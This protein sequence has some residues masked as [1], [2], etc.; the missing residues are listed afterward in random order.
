MI[1]I[2][3]TNS[4]NKDFVDL[5]KLLDADLKKRDGDEH[6]FYAQFNKIDG[7]KNAVV[8]YFD[9]LPVGCGSIKEYTPNIA[10]IKRMYVLPKN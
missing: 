3:R 2:V 7:I 6:P 1:N 10:E 5:V 8:A 9:K 4:D